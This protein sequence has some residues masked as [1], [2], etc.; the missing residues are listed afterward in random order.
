ML[1]NQDRLRFSLFASWF[2]LAI[3]FI[4]YISNAWFINTQAVFNQLDALNQLVSKNT[5]QQSRHLFQEIQTINKQ[6][7]SE[8]HQKRLLPTKISQLHSMNFDHSF[9]I[10]DKGMLLVSSFPHNT[11]LRLNLDKNIVA[12]TIIDRIKKSNK[13]NFI[14][15]FSLGAGGSSQYLTMCMPTKLTD[16]SLICLAISTENETLNWKRINE[17]NDTSVRIIGSN[18]YLLYSDPLPMHQRSLLGKKIP[19]YSLSQNLSEE[20]IKS[21]GNGQFQNQMG[22]DNIS[23]MGNIQYIEEFDLYIVISTPTAQ[24]VNSWLVKITPPLL[25]IT[26][27]LRHKLHRLSLSKTFFE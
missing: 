11:S 18:N 12:P 14:P 1:I 23:R 16:A 22:L 26:C 6:L 5:K 25:F 17:I 20:E 8:S 2:V 9:L 10:D 3:L 13:P 7:I 15:T 19:P 24:L 21:T 4:G 27:L